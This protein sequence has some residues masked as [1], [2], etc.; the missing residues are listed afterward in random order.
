MNISF[1]RGSARV[2]YVDFA[3][4]EKIYLITAY[5]KDHQDNLSSEQKVNIKRLILCLE[6]EL[7]KGEKR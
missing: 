7:R 5:T 4:Y 1:K 6:N 3:M 2:L